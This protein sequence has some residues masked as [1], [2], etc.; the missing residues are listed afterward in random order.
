MLFQ[1]QNVE[2]GMCVKVVE[3]MLKFTFKVGS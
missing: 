2:H 3:G 1:N